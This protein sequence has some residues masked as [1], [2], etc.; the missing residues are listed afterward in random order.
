M[1]QKES[2][3]KEGV[4][5]KLT[6]LSGELKDLIMA[7]VGKVDTRIDTVI[8]TQLQAKGLIGPGGKYKTM[9]DWAE[10]IT[11]NSR[12]EHDALSEEFRKYRFKN[13]QTL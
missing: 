1:L 10:W 5:K 13:Q 7:S 12:T 11:S 2:A 4:K 3:T 6:N 9:R 8:E